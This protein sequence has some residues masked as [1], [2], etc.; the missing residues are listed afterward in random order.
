MARPAEC[1][2]NVLLPRHCAS[3]SANIEYP[4]A[5]EPGMSAAMTTRKDAG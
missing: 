2:S 5:R 3:Q 4:V 1:A